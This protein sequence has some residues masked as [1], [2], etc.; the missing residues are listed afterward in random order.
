MGFQLDAVHPLLVLALRQLDVADDKVFVPLCGKSPDLLYLAQ[1]FQ[2]VGAELSDIA[3]RDFFKDHQLDAVQYQSDS[4]TCFSWRNISLWQGD[5][6]NLRPGQFDDISLVYDR[7]AL[8]A[9]PDEM[10]QQYAQHLCKLVAPGAQII[11]I[12]LEYPETEKQGPP[13]SVSQQQLQHL[14][15]RADI[16]LLAEQDLTGKG[17]A[18]R[19][20]ATS[21]LSEKAYLIKLPA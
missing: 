15:P 9:L 11:L 5:F 21:Y 3:C 17:F 4:F 14:F 10:R 6:F 16:Q 2:V 19:R 12:S 13:F 8:I 18:K 20:F 7:A 1:R